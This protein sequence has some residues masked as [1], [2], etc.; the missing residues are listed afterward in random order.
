M[1]GCE[2]IIHLAATHADFHKNYFTTNHDGTAVL[3]RAARQN[4]IQKLVFYS[5]VAVYGAESNGATEAQK[6]TPNAE[7]GASKLAAED[8]IRAWAA[9]NPNH[10]A[11]IIRPTVVFGP[12]NFANVFNLMRQIDSGF[13]V[14]VGT[15]ENIKSIAYV[16]KLGR[17]HFEIVKPSKARRIYL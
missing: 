5:S 8:L 7:Y 13:Y 9:E 16:E 4:K 15:G 12:Y 6:P 1:N 14:N 17:G 10:S 11:L 3:L 2:A